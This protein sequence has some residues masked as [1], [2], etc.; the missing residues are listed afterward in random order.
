MLKYVFSDW[1]KLL[2]NKFHYD[3]SKNKYG[4]NSKLLFTDTDTL[5]QE[6]KTE[7][8]YEV[9]SK[10]NEKFEIRNYSTKPKL[11]DHSNKLVV[12]KMK[13]ETV[14]VATKEFVGLIANMYSLLVYI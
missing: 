1:S 7:D 2:M 11:Y 4:N 9:F 14:S 6:I 13:D 12:G 8:V 3:Y 5:M 10:E